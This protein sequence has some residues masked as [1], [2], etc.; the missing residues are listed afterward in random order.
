MTQ[1]QFMK[2]LASCT[3]FNEG[4]LGNRA[5]R[6]REEGMLQKGGRGLAAVQIN[7][8]EG[9]IVLLSA[10]SGSS[11]NACPTTVKNLPEGLIDAIAEILNDVSK[12]DMIESFTYDHINNVGII[13]LSDGKKEIFGKQADYNSGVVHFINGNVLRLLSLVFQDKESK[14]ARMFWGMEVARIAA[15]KGEEAAKQWMEDHPFDAEKK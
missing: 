14:K 15:T 3:H 10:M 4:D 8:R 12:A 7:A 13:T 9:A 11:A 2:K 5:N 6:L 1:S